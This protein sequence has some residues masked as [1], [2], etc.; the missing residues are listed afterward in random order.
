MDFGKA[1]SFP[2]EDADWL[3]KIGIAALLLFI[4]LLGML[5][6]SGWSLE[7]TK[8]VI[9]K[10]PEPLAAWDD[11]G[12]YLVRGFQV[13]IIW[14]VYALPIILATTCVSVVFSAAL[15][16]NAID[17]AAGYASMAAMVCVYCLVIMYSIL[18]AFVIPAALGHFAN[19]GKFSAAFRFGEI[20]GLVRA[21]PG[22][23]LLALI[24]NIIAGFIA[25]LGVILCAVGVVLTMAYSQAIIGHLNGQAYLEATSNSGLEPVEAV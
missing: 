8:N 12:G 11:F 15:D 16:P 1:F 4:P 25:G 21:A 5:W 20:F 2:F 7:I 24:G 6:V 3:K 22:A 23:Y 17:E 19:E 13:F 9:R 18:L 14:F 10:D